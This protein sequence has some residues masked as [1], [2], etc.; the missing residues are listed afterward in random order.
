MT[1]ASEEYEF[2]RRI[3][4][5]EKKNPNIYSS[6][7]REAVLARVEKEFGEKGVQEFVKEF[8]KEYGV[9]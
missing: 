3:V 1:R 9:K 5:R 2:A 4:K 8:K 6:N 7:R